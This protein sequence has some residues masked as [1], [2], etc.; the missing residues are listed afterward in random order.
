MGITLF[1]KKSKIYLL[2][3]KIKISR[4]NDKL[5]MSDLDEDSLVLT[6]EQVGITSQGDGVVILKTSDGIRFPISAF[7]AETAKSISDFKEQNLDLMPSMYN[8]LENIC[9]NLELIL[10][11]VRIYENGK[12]LRANLYF[13]G[14]KDLV[15]RN[16][17]ASDALALATFYSVPILVKKDLLQQS[18]KIDS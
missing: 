6:I 12:S 5:R 8:M 16:Y 10:V 15:L 13:T 17:R 14:K 4:K 3:K 1:A 7:S 18:P 2:F 11:K 9:E